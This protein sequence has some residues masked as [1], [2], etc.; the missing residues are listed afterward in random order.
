MTTILIFC[1][2]A[3]VGLALLIWFGRGQRI[4]IR[5][6]QDIESHIT[7]VDVPALMNLF[8]ARGDEFL[9]A[10][11]TRPQYA[12]IR[13]ERDRVGA[14]YVRRIATNSA[15]LLRANYYARLHSADAAAKAVADRTIN[16]AVRTRAAA[17]K[18]LLLLYL[19]MLFPSLGD[20][21]GL[22]QQYQAVLDLTLASF[23][24]KAAL[25]A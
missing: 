18:I 19:R 11:L 14:E 6:L 13:R 5:S 4:A 10:R 12:Q 3:A 24:N 25:T 23:Q 15:V 21:V 2:V 16:L 22:G 9:R 1:A 17:L 20:P 8:D 7:A